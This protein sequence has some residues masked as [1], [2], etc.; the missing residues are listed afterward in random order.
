MVQSHS[1]DGTHE[2]KNHKA[3]QKKRKKMKIDLGTDPKRS[4]AQADLKDRPKKKKAAQADL[5]D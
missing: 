1:I 3:Q 5:K 2:K 4:T